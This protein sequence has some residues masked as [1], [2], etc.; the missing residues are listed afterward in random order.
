[1]A[2]G[3]V[4]TSWISP[5]LASGNYWFEITDYIGTNWASPNSSATAQRTIFLVTCA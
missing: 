4:G 3:V 5:A 2:I 1:M